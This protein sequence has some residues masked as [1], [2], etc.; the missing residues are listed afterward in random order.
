M[1][2][3]DP[4]WLRPKVHR[5]RQETEYCRAVDAYVAWKSENGALFFAEEHA[6]LAD[7]KQEYERQKARERE[8]E[9]A[10]RKTI[11]SLGLTYAGVRFSSEYGTPR[12]ITHCYACKRNLDNGIELECVACGWILCPCGAC[13]CGYSGSEDY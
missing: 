7:R 3:F 13:G 5:V 4:E 10:H 9:D 1:R 11:Q 8:I 12:R 2:Y 6:K